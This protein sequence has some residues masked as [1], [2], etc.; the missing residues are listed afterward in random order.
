[1]TQRSRGGGLGNR[2]DERHWV[3]AASVRGPRLAAAG[4]PCEDA[5]GG[6]VS[7]SGAAVAVADGVGSSPYARLGARL[8]VRAAK[9]AARRFLAAPAASPDA[10]PRFVRAAWELSLG[11]LLP[12][13]AATTCLLAV[14]APGRG[15]FFWGLGDGLAAWHSKGAVEVLTAS[16]DGFGN[17]TRALGSGRAGWIVEVRPP[18]EPGESLVLATDGIADDLEPSRVE[19]FVGWC[20]SA[21]GARAGSGRGAWLLRALQSWP[22]PNHLDDKSL[23]ILHRRAEGERNG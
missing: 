19:S 1:M 2:Y 22:V 4:R 12:S 14:D 21:L 20:V 18:L 8:A 3:A 6:V 13:D 7:S 9:E 23:A 10:V 5:C 11:E 16:R 15:V 17:E